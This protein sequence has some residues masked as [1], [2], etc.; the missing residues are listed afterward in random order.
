LDQL[1]L[2]SAEPERLAVFFSNAFGMGAVP[3]EGGWR[4]HAPHRDLLVVAGKPNQVAFFAF[5]LED[6]EALARYR[7][8]LAAGAVALGA[9]PSQRYGATAFSTVDPDGNTAVFG[10]HSP[11]S[12]P[13][14]DRLPAR[15]QHVVFRTTNL[16][17]MVEFYERK[18]GFV[19][20]DRVKD[21]AGVLRAC[22]LRSDHEHHSL[23]IFR[24][25]ESRLDHHSYETRDWGRM[26]DWA[27]HVA[28]RGVP[29][30]WGIGRHGVGNNV[31]FMVKDP[32]DNL[33][34]ISAEIEVCAADRPE[35]L[36][37][38]EQRTLNLWGDAIMRS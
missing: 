35:G 26:R 17:A 15:L 20:S 9:N 5:A 7:E 18:L 3:T 29:L 36:W 24:A 33:V 2:Q 16:D 19:V 31:F 21:E 1:C 28:T 30:C 13:A 34:E 4:C 12:A 6:E 32:D 25:P 10:V 22:F 27:D 8:R 11:D 38:H 14:G 23:G 37:P